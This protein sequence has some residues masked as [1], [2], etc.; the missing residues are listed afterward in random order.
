MRERLT[1]ALKILIGVG[2]IYVLYLLLDNPDNL[3]RQLREADIG[4]L[5]LGSICYAGAVALS[6]IKWGVLLRAS[7]I[8]VQLRRL[9]AY[10]WVAEFFNNFLPAQVGGDIM[11]GY[12]LASDTQRTADAAASVVIDRFIGLFV[13]MAAAAVASTMMLVWGRPNG[14]TFE[15]EVLVS[16][17]V[18]ALG[19]VGVTV[20]LGAIIVAMLSRRLKEW[21]EGI[22][23]AL[24]LSAKTVPVWHTLAEAFNA[25]RHQ[26]NALLLTALG[27]MIIVVLTSINI[28]LIALALDP[29]QIS[30]VEVLAINPIIVFV[31]LIVPLS[32]G[33]LGVRQGAFVATF[34]L[35]GVSSELGFAVGLLQQFIG[36]I[37]SLPGGY[38]WM[39]GRRV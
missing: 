35:I 18:I 4:P 30:L 26:Y 28:W 1:N 3:W 6:G 13:F 27:S 36:Y 21:A 38:L 9:L 11:R 34:L 39:R 31:A 37:V 19:S 29:N 10:Q 32:P 22:L 12:A 23:S 5:L 8:N 15:G 14:T 24:P 33:G 7:G 16:M 20:L 2:L 25:Y 17:Q